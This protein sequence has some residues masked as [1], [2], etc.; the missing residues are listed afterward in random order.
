[1]LKQGTV[2]HNLERLEINS[3]A[4]VTSFGLIATHILLAQTDE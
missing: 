1:M 4:D 2:Q 3:Q